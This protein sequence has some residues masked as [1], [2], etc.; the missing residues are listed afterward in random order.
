ME[1]NRS[2]RF[3]PSVAGSF[4][5]A[6]NKIFG[7]AFLILLVTV[8]IAVLLNSPIGGMNW[9]MDN[10]HFNWPVVLFFPLGLLGL[11]YSFMFLPIIQYGKQYLFLRAMRN[12]DVDIKYL[13]DGFRKQYLNIV[14]ANLIVFAL[15]MIGTIMFVIPG[16]IIWCRLAFVPYLVMDKDMDA[17]KAIEKSWQMT[18]NHG[19]TIFGMTIIS[20]LVFIGGLIVFFVGSIISLMWIHGAFAAL[21]YA[22]DGDAVNDEIE[23]PIPILGVNEI[24]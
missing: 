3:I 1:N 22:I 9:K 24:E 13:F 8:I 11:A 15:F 14:L 17:M 5:Y 4:G 19:W 20:I 6:W 21:F 18:R 16:I 12:E 10:N 2:Y 23:N 7:P